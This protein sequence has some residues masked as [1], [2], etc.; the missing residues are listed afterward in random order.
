MITDRGKLLSLAAWLRAHR[1]LVGVLAALLLA[2]AIAG[3]HLVPRLA[4]SQIEALVVEQLQRKVVLGE[5]AFNPFTLEATIDGM[6]LTEAD[7]APLLSFRRLLVNAELASLWRRGLVLQQVALDAPDIQAIV[8]PDGSL[9][10]ARLAPPPGPQAAQG[11]THEAPLRVH[12]GRLAVEDGRIAFQ[13]RSL[14]QPFSAAFT[15]IRFSLTDFRTDV[16]H[17]NAYHFTTASRVGAKF[18]WSG[19]FT[20]QPLGSSGTFSVA[21]LRLAALDEYLEGKLPIEIVSGAL[22]LGGSYRF[23]LQPLELDI[24]LPSLGVRDLVLAERGVAAAAPVA[25][26][27]IDVHDLAF[28]LSRRDIGVRRVD[29]R[30]AR[31]DLVRESHGGLNLARLAGQASPPAQAP[32]PSPSPWTIHAD[33]IALEAATV[34]AEDRSVSPAARMQLAPIAVTL[35]GWSTARGSRMKVDADLGIDGSGR[36]GVAGEVSLEPPGAALAIDLQKFPLPALQ[37][38]L[39]R[40]T[41]LTLHSGSLG[42][43]ADLAYAAPR[44]GAR[45][46]A[47]VSAEVRIDALRATDDLVR[48]DLVKWR[49]LTVS[50]IQFQQSPDRLRI[51]RI[52]AHQPYA[53]VI[54]AQ[55]GT[56]N[57]A[58]VL[59]RPASDDA[60]ATPLPAKPP[61]A[62]A[63]LPMAIRAVQVIDG[64]AN[65]A[66]YSVQPSFASGI[67]GLAGQ[68]EGLSSAP[69]SR[70]KVALKGSV[71]EFSPVELSGEVNL[72]SAAVYTD[73]A[74]NF[75]NIELTTFNPYSGKFAGYNISKGKLS[76]GMKY[77]VENRKL[78]AQHHIVV[79][80]LEFGDKTESKDAAP[81]PVKLGVALL[82]DRRGIIEI[83]LPVS[84]TLD[85]PEF[86]LAPII[87]KAVV[88]L[89]TK[90]VTAPF[91]ALGALL[92]GGEELAFVDFRPGS[93]LLGEQETSKLGLLSKGLVERP[94]LRLSLP[95]TV[96]AAADGEAVARQALA[97]LVAPADPA[98]P[99]DE[100]AKR[101]RVEALEAAYRAQL[102][103][104]PE[105]P[106][107][108]DELGLDGRIAWLQAAL[109]EHLKPAPAALEALGRQRA[110]AVR[111]ALLANKEL[112]AERVFIV[113]KPAE[114]APAAGLVRMEMKLE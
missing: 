21:G 14:P 80:N 22:Q 99:L 1:I 28:S 20:V 74:L 114:A 108:P 91:A 31:I 70:A 47:K 66:D 103:G 98:K 3:F 19:A 48:E 77:R 73:L 101:K 32:S 33:S 65:F 42:V 72:L 39:S 84:G 81:I 23:A 110:A 41:A 78:E 61:A 100:G 35:G 63:R 5:I 38:Y 106:G 50:G 94:Q 56:T 104:A 67:V 75:R 105:Y 49:S 87:W 6:E 25:I 30:G 107:K 58:R 8:A 112:S 24:E 34:V 89:L 69:E 51:E 52:V 64:S 29:V 85:D 55:N 18:E 82:K 97:A 102:K 37:P 44:E 36:L 79:D 76:T 26:P 93:A 62:A 113:S 16:G 68:V 71:D 7:G 12:I 27:Q 96:A 111:S 57:I 17:R 59:A 4:R 53:R 90:L 46:A 54:V 95:L 10:L 83:D 9:N 88:N 11:E 15:P 13:D 45:P 86:R 43:K 60:A 92:G 109:L 40:L 2:Y